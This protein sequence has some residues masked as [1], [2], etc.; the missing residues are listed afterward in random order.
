MDYDRRAAYDE[1]NGKIA[2]TYKIK[3]EVADKFRDACEK[4]GI[5][6]AAKLQELMQ[7]FVKK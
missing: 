5:S 2:K 7:E 1:K 3:K 4:A 6:Q